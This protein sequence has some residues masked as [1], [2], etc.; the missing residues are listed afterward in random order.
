MNIATAIQFLFPTAINGIDYEVRNDGDGQFIALWNIESPE[1]TNDELSVAWV[2]YMKKKKID[3]LSMACKHAIDSP[4]VSS[5]LGSEHLYSYDAEAKENLKN[6]EA[7]VKYMPDDATV[8]WR[9][10]DT[11][12]TTPHNKEQIIQ[13]FLDS[14]QHVQTNVAKYRQLEAQV[15]TATTEEEV[16]AIKWEVE[17]DGTTAV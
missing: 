2:E 1:P 6:A 12:E 16:N 14:V 11:R 15:L 8:D 17:T 4:F 3:E 10:H 5:A 9:I 7:A 13:L